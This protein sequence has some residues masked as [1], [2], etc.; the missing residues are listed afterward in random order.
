[1]SKTE[2]FNCI[3]CGVTFER[4]IRGS[5]SR[6][7]CDACTTKR[8]TER[9]RISR[10]GGS[11]HPSGM[12]GKKEQDEQLDKIIEFKYRTENPVNY[13]RFYELVY[14]D[15]SKT[16]PHKLTAKRKVKCLGCG[17]MFSSIG[18]KRICTRCLE[19]QQHIG[20]SADYLRYQVVS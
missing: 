17:E 15:Y 14:R 8:N 10:A 16:S 13:E 2:L 18:D 3:D 11:K 20:A 9:R 4:K 7:R 12:K 1:M 5:I 6:T 19:K